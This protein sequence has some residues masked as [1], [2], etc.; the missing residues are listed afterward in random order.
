LLQK[1]RGLA[2]VVGTVF[3]VIVAAS[4]ITYVSYSMDLID[5]F[6]QSIGTKQTLDYERQTEEFEVVK[7]GTVNNKF[8]FTLQN[9]GNIP[10]NITRLWVKNTTDSTWPFS[11]FNI[12]TAV[13]PG[14]TVTNVGQ[15]IGLISLNTQSY[16]MKLVTER[17]SEETVLIN[18]A[19]LQPLDLQL[20]ALPDIIP[21]GFKTTLLLSVT[22]NMSSKDVLLNIKP[23][24]PPTVV[25]N[26]VNT[27]VTKITGPIPTEY[28]SLKSGD[29]AVFKWTYQ[30][31]GG[32]AD[33]ADFTAQL[34]NGYAGNTATVK[35]TIGEIK[36]ATE[37]FTS[38]STQ[39][40]NP[41]ASA[42]DDIILH[43]ES[44]PAPLSTAFQ[45]DQRVADAAGFNIS[46]D[47]TSP[48]FYTNNGTAVNVTSGIWNASLTYISDPFPDIL[49]TSMDAEGGMIFHFEDAGAGIDGDEDN[50][51]FCEGGGNGRSASY[52]GGLNVNDWNEF[53]GPH[54]SGSYTFGGVDDFFFVD[55]ARCNEVKKDDASVAGWFKASS[56]GSGNDYIYWAGKDGGANK[57]RFTV[58]IDT[59]DDVKFEFEDN[60]GDETKCTTSGT[61]YR[62]DNWHHF[63]GVRTGDYAC[64]LFIDGNSVDTGSTIPSGGDPDVKVDEVTIGARLEDKDQ[65]AGADFWEGS[66]DDIMV[67]QKR[68]LNSGE[69]TDLYNTNYGNTA[70]KITFT[71]DRTDVSGSFLQTIANNIQ[72]PMNFSDGKRDSQFLKSFN[73]TT[74]NRPEI[75]FGQQ[76]RLKFKMEFVTFEEDLDMTFRVDDNALTTNPRTSYIDPPPQNATFAPYLLYDNDTELSTGIVSN[77]PESAW[78]TKAGTRVVFNSTISDI[79]YAGI[80]KSANTTVLSENQDST[81]IKIGESL[82][83]V[84]HRPRLEP[85]NCFPFHDIK[86]P[87]TGLIIPGFYNVMIHIS[88]YDDQGQENFWK[89]DIGEVKVVD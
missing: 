6:A 44:V 73:Y 47:T 70:H 18:S 63:V 46:I 39:N 5:N 89:I 60:D 88:G 52:E 28:S 62:D 56:S 32:I 80:I 29:T 83:L 22:N 75:I 19:S 17:G 67:W 43:Q 61:N 8:N 69:V 64:E 3:F 38:F 42:T 72:Y 34:V 54:G 57:E 58:F 77:G 87:D 65:P 21:D 15:N 55:K 71:L 41:P 36:V 2:T 13:A 50:S 51:F 25:P 35:T 53:G 24:D 66:L 9:T 49:A 68:K 45:L 33:F 31:D 7:V 4:I 48:E 27:V 16:Y 82:S 30:I 10:V 74:D 79:S 59:N 23:V 85:N 84:F 1:R 86:C 20:H 14:A 76:E 78:L 40:F 12:N 37:A 11:K 81:F 26:N